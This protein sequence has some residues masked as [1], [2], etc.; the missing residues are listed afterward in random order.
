MLMM[1]SQNNSVVNNLLII[2][3]VEEVE[4]SHENLVSMVDLIG[5]DSVDFMATFDLKLANI[6]LGLGPHSSSFSC[7]RCELP[8]NTF[9]DSVRVIQLRTPGSIRQNTSAYMATAANH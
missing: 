3:L 8:K 7:P 5:V 6:F 1:R 4:D 2:A 9:S